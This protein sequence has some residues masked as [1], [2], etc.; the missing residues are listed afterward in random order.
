MEDA[1]ASMLQG[2]NL[3]SQEISKSATKAFGDYLKELGLSVEDENWSEVV[4]SSIDYTT[5]DSDYNE[6]LGKVLTKEQINNLSDD[7]NINFHVLLEDIKSS[8]KAN[9][10]M[11]A[12][13][14]LLSSGAGKVDESQVSSAKTWI[15]DKLKLEQGSAIDT[16]MDSM[17]TDI[18]GTINKGL[19][20][21]EI[22]ENLSDTFG[23]SIKKQLASGKLSI[24]DI[25]KNADQLMESL[26]DPASFLSG[27]G[28]TPQAQTESKEDK[29]ARRL[30]KNRAER[31]RLQLLERKENKKKRKA[32][33]K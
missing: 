9:A 8:K 31:R 20:F 26:K 12:F 25:Q 7:Q 3:V 30:E 14:K 2:D 19:P 16:I 15:K 24:D 27:I 23:D 4:Y 32:G 10:Q 33:K 21:K 28:D 11:G 18:S 1:I 5:S 22:I 17:I 6:I 13:D 29:L